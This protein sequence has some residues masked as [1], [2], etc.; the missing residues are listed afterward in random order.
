MKFEDVLHEKAKKADINLSETQIS[1][2]NLYYELLLETNK[3]VNLTAI[4]EPEAVA[5][6]H[7]IDSLTVYEEKYFPKQAKV[8][9]IGTGAGFPGIPLKIYQ[10]SLNVLLVDS[11]AKR[12]RFLD[13]VI[14]QLKLEEIFTCH[15]RAEDAGRDKKFREKHDV[16]IARA[17]APLNVL[18][19]YCLPL[20][21]TGGIFAAMKAKQ[22]QQ[23][24]IDAKKAIKLLGA[25]IEEVKKISLP[26]L[27]DE[28]FIIYLRKI[29]DTPNLYPR[30]AGVPERSPLG[31]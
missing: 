17:V 15:A 29:K 6:K 14:E 23:E 7:F 5:V 8:C 4:T 18:G 28:R 9:D 3:N 24:V 31:I 19:E 12:L 22:A 27:E 16:V 10:T 2:F 11:L 1:A 21:K 20:V 26:D 30:K 25:E 13:N